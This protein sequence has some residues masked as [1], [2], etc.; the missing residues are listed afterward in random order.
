M[1]LKLGGGTDGLN[2]T[3]KVVG[4]REVGKGGAVPGNGINSIGI[5]DDGNGGREDTAGVS[6]DGEYRAL[7]FV[8]EL[9][10][11]HKTLLERALAAAVVA[12][13]A[14]DEIL[15]EIN[16]LGSVRRSPA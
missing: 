12:L 14:V 13:L 2:E 6:T 5:V 16:G 10:L 3:M 1:A 11:A 9:D 4:G 15:N 8:D 7:D